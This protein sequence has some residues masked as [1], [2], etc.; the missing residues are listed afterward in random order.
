MVKYWP[1]VVGRRAL[2]LAC[3]TGR[4]SRLLSETHAAHVVALDVCSPM[5]AQ[6]SGA[7]RV[8]ASMMHLPFVDESFDFVISGLALG[9]ASGIGPWMTEVA[10]VLGHGGDLLY[11]DFHPEAARAGLPRTF[12]DQSGRTFTVPH[13]CYEWSSQ[14]EA[15]ASANLSINAVH[16]IRVGIELQ[17]RFSE[18][19]EFYRRWHG[20]PIVLVVRARKRR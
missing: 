14:Q 8:R 10:R 12:K 15:A 1:D 2:D 9:H 18:S 5:L 4:Y 7:S 13:H 17:E 19:D 11:S 3:G 6:V 16:E 20:L